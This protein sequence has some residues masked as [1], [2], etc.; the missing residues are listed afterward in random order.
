MR[1]GENPWDHADKE[2]KI[3]QVTKKWVRIGS[4]KRGAKIVESR[5]LAVDS[6]QSVAD[7]SNFTF[8]L[9]GTKRCRAK[10]VKMISSKTPDTI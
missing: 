1:S 4:F 7:L 5:Q 6:G 9:S 10:S 2:M 3:R 8:Q